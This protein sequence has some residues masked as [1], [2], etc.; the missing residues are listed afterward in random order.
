MFLS[1]TMSAALDRIAERAADVRRAFTPGA[2]P[3]HDDVATPAAASDFTLDPLA[4]AAP[5]GTYFITDDSEGRRT[6]T[7]DGAFIIRAGKLTDGDGR[8]IL[9]V[10]APEGALREMTVDVVDESL[11]RVR[12]AHVDRDGSLVYGREVVDPRT[13]T[14]ELQRVIVGRVALARF[15]AGTKLETNDGSHCL[16]PSGVVPSTGLPADG[17]FAPLLPMHRERSRIDVNESLVRL[18]DAYLAFDALQAAEAAKAHVGKTT[19]DLLK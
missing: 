3:Q 14:K 11:G 18:K 6:Y 12:D 7:R 10:G 1:S 19:L 17:K 8:P 15:P 9:G 16:P 4:V 5:D 13:G 2:V